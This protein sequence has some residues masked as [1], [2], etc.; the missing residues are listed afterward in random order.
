MTSETLLKLLL[1]A[2]D[3][4]G[5]VFDH[6]D[7]SE[8][9]P[10]ALADYERLGLLRPS[11]NGLMAPCPHCEDRHVEVVALGEGPDGQ[12][13]CYIW[14]PEE[15]RVEVSP[16]MCRGW[17]VSPDGLAAAVAGGLAL[18][19]TPS[20]VLPNRLWRLG[21]IPW[22]GKTREVVLASRLRDS[23]AA[24]VAAHV[25]AGGRSIV[26]VPHHIP[27]ER[28]WPGRV[29][30]VIALARIAMIDG[31]RFVIDGVALVDLVTEADSIVEAASLLPIDPEIKK[32]VVRRQVKAEIKG[33]LED[34]V[35]IAARLTHGSTRKAATAL[36]EQLGRPVSKDQVQRAIDRAGGLGA[37]AETE[38]SASVA[39]SVASQSRDRAKKISQRR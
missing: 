19:G 25:G 21:R 8:W 36:T 35:L 16:E 33:H 2:A 31:P 26:L 32:R 1:V 29:P 5:R 10:G 3:E 22:E 39:R 14:C 38:D 9:P 17:E 11:S 20:V 7:I 6:L 34:D 24:S 18:K 28:I 13:R 12:R 15:L 23:D 4:A 27:D 30:A 37:L